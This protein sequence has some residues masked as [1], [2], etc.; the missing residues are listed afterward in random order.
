MLDSNGEYDKA[1]NKIKLS[2]EVK[3]LK[4]STE[5]KKVESPLLHDLASLQKKA[6]RNMI[7]YAV[8]AVIVVAIT[9][10]A[11]NGARVI[12]EKYEANKN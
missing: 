9:T 4:F 11:W 10:L 8:L 6:T 2:P 1:F 12:F 5:E 7:I 3:V